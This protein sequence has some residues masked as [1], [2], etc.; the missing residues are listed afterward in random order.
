MRFVE[1]PTSAS[2]TS[3]PTVSPSSSAFIVPV[4]P[5]PL[6][7]V[8][9]DLPEGWH[10]GDGPPYNCGWYGQQGRCAAYGND[11]RNFG[12]TANQACCGC[13]GGRVES[14]TS[15]SLTSE[16]TV[17]PFIA[18]VVPGPLIEVCNDLPEG[19]HD[20][21]GPP[22][23]CGWYGQQGRCALYGND[24]RNFN[25]TANQACCGCG[26]GQM[27][28]V[29]ASAAAPSAGTSIQTASPSITISVTPSSQTT[30][31]SSMSPT[32]DER[33]FAQGSGQICVNVPE[34]WHDTDGPVYNCDWYA[35][36]TNCALF[37]GIDPNFGVTANQACCACG[38]GEPA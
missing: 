19:W 29:S 5:G 34:T 3:E 27:A 36:G 8:C 24:Y 28:T 25:A 14:P 31:L 38:G 16:P 17:S 35:Q 2:L 33:Q 18:P 13:G 12:A 1:S 15:A 32:S 4:V 9:N 10:D 26:G 7:E 30:G 23:N 22:Y 21:D 11:Y 37:G 20:G 6:I